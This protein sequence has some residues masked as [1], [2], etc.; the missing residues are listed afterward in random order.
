MTTIKMEKI[1]ITR[2]EGPTKNCCITVGKTFTVKTWGQA[3]GHLNMI[4]HDMRLRGTIGY[5]KTDFVV[6][7]ENGGTY[8][9]RADVTADGDDTD[10]AQLIREEMG[11]QAGTYRPRHIGESDWQRLRAEH[12]SE[13]YG[14]SAREFLADYDLGD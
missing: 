9:G 5:D 6:T 1:E 8:A 11:F 2:G 10:L 14:Q 7:F 4:A 3:K 12:E 13:G